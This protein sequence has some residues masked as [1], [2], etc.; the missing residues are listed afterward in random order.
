MN[1][2]AIKLALSYGYFWYL[3]WTEDWFFI[4]MLI[5]LVIT[6]VQAT[7]LLSQIHHVK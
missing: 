6:Q 1:R 2:A 3:G 5:L 4:A 7:F